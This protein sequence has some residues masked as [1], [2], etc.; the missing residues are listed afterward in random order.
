M[1]EV[2]C[3]FR[4][5]SETEIEGRWPEECNYHYCWRRYLM[6]SPVRR[7][8][9]REGI[10]SFRQSQMNGV[11]LRRNYHT[12]EEID[13]QKGGTIQTHVLLLSHQKP[14]GWAF[15]RRRDGRR[16]EMSGTGACMRRPDRNRRSISSGCLC[17]PG[18]P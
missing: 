15:F 8:D 7:S 3:R 10:P 18:F 17:V 9:V 11:K 1:R 2:M 4:L 13:I 16:A 6:D 14:V 5:K 12:K